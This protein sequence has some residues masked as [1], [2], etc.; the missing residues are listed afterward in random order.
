VGSSGVLPSV[1]AASSIKRFLTSAGLM[2]FSLGRNRVGGPAIFS[3]K[4]RLPK[5]SLE[6]YYLL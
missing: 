6:E 4:R 1:S 2:F 3:L 5:G